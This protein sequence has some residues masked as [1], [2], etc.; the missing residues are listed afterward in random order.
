MIWLA[1]K[2]KAHKISLFLLCALVA[3]CS[4]SHP[5]E[6]ISSSG[7][8]AFC[9][10]TANSDRFDIYLLDLTTHS[11]KNLTKE[12]IYNI[13]NSFGHSIGCSDDMTPYRIS[14]LEWAPSGD[15]LIVNASEPFLTI[16]YVMEISLD[17]KVI[18]ITRQRSMSPNEANIL[19]WPNEYSWSPSEDVVAFVG[20][21]KPDGFQNLFIGDLSNW[22]NSADAGKILQI[23]NIEQDW[24][25]IIY[26]PSWSP[27]GQKIAVSINRHSSGVAILSKDGESSVFVTNGNYPQLSSVS[28]PTD[29][30]INVKPSWFPDSKS[31]V[32]IGAISKDSRTALFSI[33]NDGTELR[34]LIPNGVS[35]PVVSPSGDSIAYIEYSSHEIN[36][37]GRIVIVDTDGNHKKIIATIKPDNFF[38]LKKYY[39]RDLSW[40][41]DG[42]YLVFTSNKSGQF[43]LYLVSVNDSQLFQITNFDGNAVN[44]KWRPTYYDNLP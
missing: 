37:I 32:F 1:D 28:N 15:L 8:I 39:I 26:S 10:K 9:G 23:T 18:S 20:V 19:E 4:E 6:S 7:H 27:D 41:P 17:G 33:N 29:P 31:L 40:S 38:A 21:N 14:G 30:W 34:L 3:A 24:P 25:G 11:I 16:P 13:D 12:F 22:K 43:Q 44:P 5:L 42:K 35:N 2:M 36:T